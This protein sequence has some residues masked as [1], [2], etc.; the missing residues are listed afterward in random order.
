MNDKVEGL[1][2]KISDYK[3]ND[4]LIDCLTKD[5]LF[6]SFVARG[7]KKTNRSS[8]F[9]NFCLYEFIFNYKDNKTMFTINDSKLI[10]NY[11][12]DNLKLMAFKDILAEVS[13]KSKE[14]GDYEMFDKLL[15]V[16]DNINEKNC[17][18][19]GSLYLAYILKISGI[20]PEVDGCVICGNKKV[21]SISK[22]LGGFVCINHFQGEDA[23]NVSSLK[24]FRMINKASFENY[25][26][27][28]DIEFDFE[29]FELLVAF[30]ETN[31]EI[32]LKA[33]KIYRELFI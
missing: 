23:M 7:A 2:L 1:V 12:D 8:C 20:A 13:L 17:Y 32:N 30:Y 27:I 11:Y 33:F 21:V 28:K 15:F 10:H 31:S 3:E 29:D 5:H 25:D 19:L 9:Y 26:I 22:R 4:L 16:F 24:K 18:L 14:L 6:F